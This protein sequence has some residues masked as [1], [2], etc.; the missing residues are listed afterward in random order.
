MAMQV[1]VMANTKGGA[2]K[3]TVT[4]HLSAKAAEADGPVCVM[5]VD[6]Q[7]NSAQWWNER[8]ATDVQFAKIDFS[9]LE[10]Q[11]R[12]LSEAGFKY[13]FIDTPPLMVENVQRVIEVADLVIVPTRPSPM[14]LK[15]LGP[16]VGM[17]K[18]V[19]KRPL[20]VI[21]GATQRAR[22]TTDSAIALSVH[23][24]VAPTVLYQRTDYAASVGDGRTAQE[25]DPTGRSAEEIEQ[26]W[27]FVKSVLS[28][29][30]A[31]KKKKEMV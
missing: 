20:F 23:G 18:A 31:Q 9:D 15:K 14:D 24:A 8:E 28:P 7:G 25:L 13:V 19:G 3:S 30:V 12:S 29:D 10:N 11:L 4:V 16:T 27:T 26:L 6:P 5:D 1:V 21:V 22:I 2:G 17:C